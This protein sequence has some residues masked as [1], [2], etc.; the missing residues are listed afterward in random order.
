[1]PRE[2]WCI[3]FLQPFSYS[4][5]FS[6][7]SSSFLSSL[8]FFFLFL[9]FF[10]CPNSMAPKKMPDGLLLIEVRWGNPST[11]SLQEKISQ[12]YFQHKEY[13]C[14]IFSAIF[15]QLLFSIFLLFFLFFFFFFF[16]FLLLFLLLYPL[17]LLPLISSFLLL[18]GLWLKKKCLLGFCLC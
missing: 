1:M 12:W 9:I 13:P 15:L 6:S 3:F 14:R 2:A 8:F 11:F 5:S 17:P 16:F 10:L 18:L 4:P 7:F